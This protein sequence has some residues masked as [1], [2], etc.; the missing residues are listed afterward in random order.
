V[1]VRAADEVTA[2]ATRLA[3]AGLATSEENDTS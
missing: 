1:E 2:A 3:D